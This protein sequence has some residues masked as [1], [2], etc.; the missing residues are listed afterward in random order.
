MEQRDAR[1]GGGHFLHDH[2]VHVRLATVVVRAGLEHRLLAADKL[3]DG[4]R[5]EPRGLVVE[6]LASPRVVF[7]GHLLAL[8]LVVYRVGQVD[9]LFEQERARLRDGERHNVLALDFD[10]LGLLDVEHGSLE[11][12]QPSK[13]EFAIPGPLDV[14]SRELVAPVALD[15]R[16]QVEPRH[17]TVGRDFPL[18]GKL[19]PQRQVVRLVGVDTGVFTPGRR[20]QRIGNLLVFQK[21]VV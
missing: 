17:A 21:V 16:P 10:L 12:P 5:A 8:S 19:A 14:L 1:R 3:G 6:E 7:G 11:R 15:P 20:H 13:T 9:H 18:L 2:G 4:V